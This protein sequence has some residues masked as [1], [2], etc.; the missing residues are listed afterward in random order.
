MLTDKKDKKQGL[1]FLTIPETFVEYKPTKEL[2]E[3][4]IN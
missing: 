1:T 2:C 3:Y 4:C